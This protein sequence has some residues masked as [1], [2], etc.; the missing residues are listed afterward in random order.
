[1][2]SRK[3]DKPPTKPDKS[4]TFP[5]VET[6]N[7]FQTLGRIPQPYSYTSALA[8]D[9]AFSINAHNKQIDPF[10]SKYVTVIPT[11]RSVS[12]FQTT[13]NPAPTYLPKP[14]QH[15]LFYIEPSLLSLK[16]PAQ[17][18]KTYFP[19]N[20]HFTPEHPE[21]TLAYY[22]EIL[23]Q[24]ASVH[25]KPITDRIDATKIIYHSLY[26]HRVLTLEQ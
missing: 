24:T 4:L 7:R 21:K 23:V 13:D 26:I 1:M 25:F 19:R 17:I 5:S 18:A 20:W 2:S 15:K 3:T 6:T 11:S 16:D 10:A 12:Q 14:A 8:S 22:K 9:P